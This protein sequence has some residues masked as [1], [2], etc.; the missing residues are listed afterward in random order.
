MH[1]LFV[2]VFAV[3][4]ACGTASIDASD[5]T[6]SD[7]GD[8]IEATTPIDA[9]TDTFDAQHEAEAEADAPATI[10]G[11]NAPGLLLCDEF[12]ASSIDA[13]TWTS[14]TNNGGLLEL[15]TTHAHSGAQSLHAHVPPKAGADA[16]V[17]ETK[18]FPQSASNLYARAWFYFEP[19]APIAHVSYFSAKGPNATYTFASQSGTLMSLAY[20]SSTETANHSATGVP[21]G[22]W[23]CMEWNFDAGA[24]TADYWLD[25]TPLQDLHEGSWGKDAFQSHDFGISLFG[26]DTGPAAYDVW[27]DDIAVATSRIGC[28]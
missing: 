11:C 20:F 8:D 13:S 27:L 17:T 16:H 25:G 9:S 10:T 2:F 14:F 22:H 3:S 24:G 6:V 28:L 4:T 5:A 26:T 7:A 21:I 1:R 23:A 18:T 12:E 15:S 19:S